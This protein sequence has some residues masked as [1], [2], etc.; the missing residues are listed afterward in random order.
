LRDYTPE[1]E[2]FRDDAMALLNGVAITIAVMGMWT[3]P[4][5][6]GIIALLVAVLAYFM[7]PRS[8]GGTVLAVMIIMV[9]ALL[10]TWWLGHSLA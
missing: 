1:S 10:E 6:M 7:S 8:R 9:V 4:V 3:R 2:S 5:F